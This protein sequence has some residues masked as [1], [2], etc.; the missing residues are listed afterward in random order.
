MN[1][2]YNGCDGM[3]NG[4]GIWGFII[5]FFILA[6]AGGFGAFGASNANVA[7]KD[8]LTSSFNF[9]SVDNELRQIGNGVAQSNFAISQKLNAMSAQQ[10]DCCCTTQKE[11]MASRYDAERNSCNIINAVHSENEATRAL[12][13][14]TEMQRLRDKLEQAEREK[15]A[16]QY[17]LSQNVQT[18]N[19]VNELRPCAKPCYLTCSP[20]VSNSCGG[21]CGYAG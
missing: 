8:D 5:V 15:L 20:Y 2:N 6:M 3:F 11:I 17:Q 10:A 12:F 9:N 19:I 7:T 18:A 1:E 13:N 21:C 4:N 14:S 16:C